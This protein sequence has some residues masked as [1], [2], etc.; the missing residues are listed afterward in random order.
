MLK[1]V[2][3]FFSKKYLYRQVETY[4][5][6]LCW[7]GETYC[8]NFLWFVYDFLWFVYKQVNLC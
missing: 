3:I 2:I 5:N 4:P 1:P 6:I 7:Y 8:Y